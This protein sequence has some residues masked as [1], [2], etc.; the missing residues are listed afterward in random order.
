MEKSIDSATLSALKTA[1]TSGIKTVWDRY[2]AQKPQCGFGET[3]LCCRNCMQGPCRIDPFGE[4]PQTGVCGANADVMV[5]RWVAGPWR[6]ARHRTAA[7]PSTWP[8]RC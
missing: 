7:T 1:E 6:Q 5:A 2:E 8:T 3:G 4:G